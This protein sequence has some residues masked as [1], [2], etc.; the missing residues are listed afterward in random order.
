MLFNFSN[1][2]ISISFQ[3]KTKVRQFTLEDRQKNNR[4]I[5]E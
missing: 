4:I 1:S 5:S 2:P 3:S